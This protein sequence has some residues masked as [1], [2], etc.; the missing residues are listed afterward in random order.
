MGILLTIFASIVNRVFVPLQKGGQGDL[1]LSQ[2]P[3]LIEKFF[4]NSDN[5]D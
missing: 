3:L 2:N 5:L 4:D 1:L